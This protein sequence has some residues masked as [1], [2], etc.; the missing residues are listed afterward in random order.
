MST[1][2]PPGRQAWPAPHRRAL[3]AI[4]LA[5]AFGFL[6]ELVAA[7]AGIVLNPHPGW[8]AVL[9]LGARDGRSGLFDGLLAATGAVAIG[10]VVAG[11]RLATTWGRVDSDLNLIAF[12]A[13]LIVSWIASWHL[14]RHAELRERQRVLTDRAAAAEATIKSLRGVVATLRAR[15][16]RT[17]T[18]LSFLRDVAARLEGRDPIAAAEGAADL[19]LVRAGA[20]AAE[21]QVGMGKFQRVLTVRDARGPDALVPLVLRDADLTVPILNGKDRIGCL[22]LWGIPR[23]R[24]DEMTS[25][26]LAVIASWCAPALG[27]AVWRPEEPAGRVWRVT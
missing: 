9:I 15:V 26:D 8:F 4:A 12:G 25:N 7:R 16:D 11:T 18:S 17:S 10:S 21:V 6:P 2:R 5:L 24:L 3:D 1:S 27:L 14:R 19:A 22:A 13:C 20:C 23:S